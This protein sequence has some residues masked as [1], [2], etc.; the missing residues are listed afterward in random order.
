VEV[1]KRSPLKLYVKNY[2][3]PRAGMEL[4]IQ[5]KVNFHVL[6]YMKNGEGVGFRSAKQVS[7]FDSSI[8]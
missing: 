4:G 2:F 5:I 6:L 7:F 3:Q 8:L 1:Y